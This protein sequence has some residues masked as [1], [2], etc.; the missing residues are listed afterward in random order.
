M[1]SCQ[2]IQIT[3]LLVSLLPPWF[4]L[5][6]LHRPFPSAIP[7]PLHKQ[8]GGWSANSWRNKVPGTPNTGWAGHAP[9]AGTRVATRGL[10]LTGRGVMRLMV[11]RRFRSP[12]FTHLCLHQRWGFPRMFLMCCIVQ[13]FVCIPRA[14]SLLSVTVTITSW[15]VCLSIKLTFIIHHCLY[16]RHGSSRMSLIHYIRQSLCTYMGRLCLVFCL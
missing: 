14:F 4:L 13:S 11:T 3:K 8:V 16:W 5:L 2:K 1:V 7:T 15:F 10:T 9:P 6:L 12:L